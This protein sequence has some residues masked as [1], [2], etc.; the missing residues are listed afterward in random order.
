MELWDLIYLLNVFC[1]WISWHLAMRSFN[2]EN[3]I[4]GYANLFASA[5]NAA[6]V[7]NRFI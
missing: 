1:V 4:G 5:F 6:I 7:L 3:Q 2:E